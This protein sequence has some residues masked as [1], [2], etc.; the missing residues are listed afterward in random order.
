M[1]N[2]LDLF[3]ITHNSMRV[4]WVPAEGA[5]G[6]MILYAPLSDEG[7]SDEREVRERAKPT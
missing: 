6:Y 4:Q 7:T 5:S 3:D 2:N 1:V